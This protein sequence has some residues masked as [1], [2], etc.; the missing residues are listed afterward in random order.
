MGEELSTFPW[1][2]FWKFFLLLLFFIISVP[3]MALLTQVAYGFLISMGIMLCYPI[4]I[5]FFN[6]DFFGLGTLDPYIPLLIFMFFAFQIMVG[7]SYEH[8]NQDGSRDKRFKDNEFEYEH[9]DE[10]REG[11]S[12]VFF[13]SLISFIL[14]GLLDYFQIF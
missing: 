14:F 11:G 6:P 12:A 2:M 8:E 1:G 13:A 9:D 3:I 7:G 4:Y 10:A 5:K